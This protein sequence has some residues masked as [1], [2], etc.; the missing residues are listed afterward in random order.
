LQYGGIEGSGIT[1]KILYLLREARFI[2]RTDPLHSIARRKI[3]EFLAWQFLGII[4]TV[5]ISLTIAAIGFPV[6]I[7]TLIP[8]RWLFLPTRFTL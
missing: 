8:L 3:V 1:A 6:L 2:P 4:T 7:L 5:A